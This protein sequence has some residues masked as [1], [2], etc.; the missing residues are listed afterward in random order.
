MLYG[1]DCPLRGDLRSPASTGTIRRQVWCKTCNKGLNITHYL[2]GTMATRKEERVKLFSGIFSNYLLPPSLSPD[3]NDSSAR[4][5]PFHFPLLSCWSAAGCAD[6]SMKAL[7]SSLS[8]FILSYLQT[9]QGWATWMETKRDQ[10]AQNSSVKAL[11]STV[12]D[13]ILSYSSCKD[14]QRWATWMEMKREN[15]RRKAQWKL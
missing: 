6:G 14:D 1:A 8:D 4:D 2:R 7:N 15:R 12:W 9:D 11:N 13:F 3:C 10:R 5:Y